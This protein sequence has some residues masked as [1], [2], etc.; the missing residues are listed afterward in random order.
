MVRY[1]R[2]KW[3]CVILVCFSE[4]HKELLVTEVGEEKM[5]ERGE[6]ERGKDWSNQVSDLCCDTADEDG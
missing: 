3:L 6:G 2:E 1:E 5:E 4:R